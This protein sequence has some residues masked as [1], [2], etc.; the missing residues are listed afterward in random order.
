MEYCNNGELFDYIVAKDKL[1]E[2]EAR[3]FF[4][5]IVSALGFLHRN[6][7]VH[8][9]LRPENLLLD[10]NQKLKLIDFGLCARWSGELKKLKTCCGSPA[11]AA[12]ELVMGKE[13]NGPEADVWS[14]GVLL[15]AILCGYL[16]FDD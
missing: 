9:D 3:G 8:R 2:N 15:Y 11:Y 1:N 4:R 7:F 13:Y 10:K 16:P 6:G 12:P 5:Q 14:L